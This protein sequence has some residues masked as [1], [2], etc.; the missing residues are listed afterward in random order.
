[1]FT[2]SFCTE[3]GYAVNFFCGQI[4]IFRSVFSKFA[5]PGATHPILKIPTIL[6]NTM[7][8]T[9]FSKVAIAASILSAGPHDA[10]A[11][12]NASVLVD[13]MIRRGDRQS[14]SQSDDSAD[15]NIVELAS[16]TEGFST[17]NSCPAGCQSHQHF[18]P[19][20]ALSPSLPL[21]MPPSAP[22]QK[23]P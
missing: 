11:P 5:I 9:H 6:R 14:Q 22:C 18:W 2:E 1:M 4:L 17:L 13:P 3:I 8:F 20:K 7:A 15:G 12:A 21:L 23:V 19:V 16:T 10:A